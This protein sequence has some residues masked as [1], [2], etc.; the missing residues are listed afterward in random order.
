LATPLEVL[1]W[2]TCDRWFDSETHRAENKPQLDRANSNDTTW[3]VTASWEQLALVTDHWFHLRLL[4][5]AD[6]G[7]ELQT[8]QHSISGRTIVLAEND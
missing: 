6:R 1:I 7:L 8:P 2:L 3:L 5:C 4:S